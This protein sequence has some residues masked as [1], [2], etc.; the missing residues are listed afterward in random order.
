MIID[1]V[2]FSPGLKNPLEFMTDPYI[3]PPLAGLASRFVRTE[4]LI[5]VYRR[6]SAVNVFGFRPNQLP[7]FFWKASI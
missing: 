1:S 4:Y 5:H 2:S 3:Q 7:S 6:S